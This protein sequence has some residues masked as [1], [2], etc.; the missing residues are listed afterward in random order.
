MVLELVF[1]EVDRETA[2]DSARADNLVM[3]GRGP[4][5]FFLDYTIT[6]P[7]EVFGG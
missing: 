3:K 2:K 1:R 7:G 4:Q 5:A 6:S